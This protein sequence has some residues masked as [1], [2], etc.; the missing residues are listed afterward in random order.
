[1]LAVVVSLVAIT[2]MCMMFYFAFMVGPKEL[3]KKKKKK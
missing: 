1:M 2:V 3:E